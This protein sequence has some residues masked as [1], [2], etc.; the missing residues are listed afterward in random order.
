MA[1]EDIQEKTLDPSEKRKEDARKDGQVL[2]SKEA[3]VFAS[4]AVG[5]GLLALGG[6][7]APMVTGRWTAYF[8]LGPAQDLDSLL[9]ERLAQGWSEVLLAGLIFGLPVALGLIG[10]Q[11]A[12]GGLNF[13]PKAAGFNFGKID[14]I[15]GLGRMVSVQALVELGKGILKVVALGGLAVMAVKD[16]IPAFADLS[17][18][19]PSV[20]LAV[21]WAAILAL[22]AWLCLGLLGIG[23]LDL[24]WQFLSLRKKLMMSFQEMKEESKEANGSPEVKGRMRRLQMEASRRSG[25]QR[26]ALGDV[27]Q[28]TAIVTNP[29]HF[30]VA[31][32]YVPGEM[33]APVVLAM[34][35]GP[36]A[37]E[38]MA[39]GRAARVQVLQSPPLARALYFTG[40]IGSEIPP[41]LYGPVAAILAHVYRL[42][43]GEASDL[44]EIDLPEDLH[45]NEFGQRQA[46]QGGHE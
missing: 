37:Q 32:R 2:T 24:A 16:Q 39:R 12:M 20:G 34:G 4:V 35:K 46:G 8:Q 3:F 19:E 5:T 29:T 36:M 27:P 22:M 38:I 40:E 41:G 15:K 7:I 44:P 25:Q 6:L 26:A 30:A 1:E 14:P 18:V 10:L 9:T 17:M 21:L 28:A 43:R 31:L 13:A 45:F 11:L 42:D 33:P 23:G